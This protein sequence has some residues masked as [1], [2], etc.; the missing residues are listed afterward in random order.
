VLRAAAWARLPLSGEQLQ[1]LLAAFEQQLPAASMVDIRIALDAAVLI[2]LRQQ[3][4]ISH[5]Q[6]DVLLSAWEAQLPA[7]QAEDI[8]GML[9]GLAAAGHK[10]RNV[11]LQQLMSRFVEVLPEAAHWQI[12][13]VLQAL[14]TLRLSVHQ[15]HLQQL[16]EAFMQQVPPA[17]AAQSM[18]KVVYAV[19]L[20]QQG[21]VLTQEQLQRFDEVWAQAW[22]GALAKDWPRF[23]SAL[24][25]CSQIGFLPTMF[26]D[27]AGDTTWEQLCERAEAASV[28]QITSVVTSLARLGSSK[29]MSRAYAKVAMQRLQNEG[30]AGFGAQAAAGLCWA[31]AIR[32]KGSSPYVR[33]FA[34]ACREQW[35]ALGVPEKQMLN[36]VHLMRQV[37]LG[38]PLALPSLSWQLLI[39]WHEFCR[40]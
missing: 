19:A 13:A 14:G 2:S 27:A 12:T 20:M 34:A 39:G 17:A 6:I 23:Y 29:R 9:S 18:C 11:R 25:A 16:L 35:D 30:A 7:A 26:L 22:P 31:M 10:I 40:R 4:P 37:C 3:H 1:Q 32:S 15:T 21:W 28:P 33:I 38:F 24:W 36:Q 8:A 5:D